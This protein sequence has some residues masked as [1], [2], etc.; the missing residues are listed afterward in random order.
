MHTT[1]LHDITS[2][3]PDAIQQH[4][5]T[6]PRAHSKSQSDPDSQRLYKVFMTFVS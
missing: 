2:E 1:N 6:A 5:G 4:S 3:H